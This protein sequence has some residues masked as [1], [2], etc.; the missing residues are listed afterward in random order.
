M[1]LNPSSKS[2]MPPHSLFLEQDC[3]TPWQIEPSSLDII[4]TSNFFEHLPHKKALADTLVQAHKALKPRGKLICLGP[5]MSQLHGQYWDFWDHYLPLTDKSLCEG[6][7][8]HGF[9]IQQ[10]F[11][12]FLPYTMEGKQPATPWQI[13]AY[14]KFPLA[15]KILGKQFL[16][17]AEK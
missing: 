1:D 2:Y 12:K 13:K 9:Q 3:S 16:I 15:W 4:F 14:L 5:N 8:L 7:T 6:L 11:P 10:N 17:I